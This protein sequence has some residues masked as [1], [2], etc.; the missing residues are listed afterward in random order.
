MAGSSESEE[1]E[2]VQMS[3]DIGPNEPMFRDEYMGG[4]DNTS[5]NFRRLKKKKL[6]RF[7]YAVI[8]GK[9]VDVFP[10]RYQ[11]YDHKTKSVDR[12]GFISRLMLG[13]GKDTRI[14]RRVR[15]KNT[16]YFGGL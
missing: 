9:S 7:E 4:E 15:G 12:C 8:S 13:Y 10:T 5:Y 16:H 2:V 14:V 3:F 1:I 11:A 6:G